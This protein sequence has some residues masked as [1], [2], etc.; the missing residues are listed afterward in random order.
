MKGIFRIEQYLEDTQ[1]IV[2]KF[3]KLY[4]SKLITEYQAFA[5]DIKGLDT[6]NYHFFI[7][8]L[9]M[10][11]GKNI[12]EQQEKLGLIINTVETID[13]NEKLNIQNLVG[14]NIECNLE[15]YK[16]SL[17]KMRKVEL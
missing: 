17:I 16:D 6:Y 2:V 10:K 13:G 1:Q 12:I 14:R 8:S 15:N 7:Q 3:C 5:V 9:M 11:F 4:D